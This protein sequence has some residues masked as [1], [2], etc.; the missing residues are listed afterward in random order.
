MTTAGLSTTVIVVKSPAVNWTIVLLKAGVA[1]MVMF[2]VPIVV[3]DVSVA[4]TM[5]PTVVR[6]YGVV[7]K[8]PELVVSVTNVPAATGCDH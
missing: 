8:L 6:V 3:D 7:G 5:P 2:A 4:V 1:K